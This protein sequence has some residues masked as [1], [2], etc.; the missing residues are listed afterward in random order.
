MI[1]ILTA[2]YWTW[3]LLHASYNSVNLTKRLPTKMKTFYIAIAS[4]SIFIGVLSVVKSYL[5]HPL[6]EID[7]IFVT[8][9]DRDIGH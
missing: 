8:L 4:I 1:T 6:S 9:G 5:G 3:V 7:V 2:L